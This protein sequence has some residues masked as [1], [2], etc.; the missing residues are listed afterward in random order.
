MA[1]CGGNSTLPATCCRDLN[2]G[3][4]GANVSIL[5]Y[6]GLRRSLVLVDRDGKQV[7]D[8]SANN[9]VENSVL[10]KYGLA[11]LPNGDYVVEDQHHPSYSGPR[12]DYKSSA[13]VGPA[14]IIKLK[15]F[16]VIGASPEH[17][18]SEHTNVGIHAGRKG[19]G[20][21]SPMK[22]TGPDHVTRLCIRT[23]DAA[24]SMI[25]LTMLQDPIKTLN[26]RGNHHVKGHP[27]ALHHL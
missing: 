10:N 27:I 20:H 17:K 19:V 3:F 22:G 13:R 18:H 23:T 6:D 21:Q 24:M 16:V 1:G 11:G 9:R 25:R 14:G 4:Q 7:G 26:V 12:A 15:P 2:R 5:I 8:W